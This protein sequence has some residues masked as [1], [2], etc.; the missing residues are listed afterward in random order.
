MFLLTRF[1][2]GLAAVGSKLRF[3]DCADEAALDGDATADAELRCER[4][5]DGPATVELP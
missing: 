2:S 3:R 1:G 5:P 4:L